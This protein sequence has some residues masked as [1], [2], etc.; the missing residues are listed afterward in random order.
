[1]KAE[2]LDV[3]L[4]PTPTLLN[5]PCDTGRGLFMRRRRDEARVIAIARHAN[6]QICVFS[7]IIRIPAAD[8][9]Q[10]VGSKMIGRTR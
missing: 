2:S 9:A 4:Y 3:T 6:A 8:F 1:M 10:D 5:P 7:D